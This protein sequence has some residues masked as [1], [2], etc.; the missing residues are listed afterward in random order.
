[1]QTLL[2]LTYS[3]VLEILTH[4]QEADC[5]QKVKPIARLSC[6]FANTLKQ[7]NPCHL[8]NKTKPMESYEKKFY[9]YY[10]S[11]NQHAY[12]EVYCPVHVI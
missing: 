6:Y 1:M 10:Y 4:D 2:I 12:A 8:E 11:T 3:Q 7:C 5:P 9:N